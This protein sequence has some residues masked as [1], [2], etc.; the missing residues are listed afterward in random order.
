VDINPLILRSVR[1]FRRTLGE[2]IE[3]ETLLSDGLPAALVD[4][5]QLETAVL[6][7]ALN[8]RDAMPGNGLITIETA[9]AKLL[10]VQT[11]RYPDLS[12]GW[13]I[14]IALHDNGRGIPAEDLGKV[15]EP[16]FTTKE[17][18]KGTGLGLS[19]VYG[20]AKQ[21]NGH[22]VIES[23]RGKG[24]KVSLFL[25]AAGPPSEASV[26]PSKAGS[27]I[28]VVEDDPFVRAAIATQLD[29]LGYKTLTSASA[30]EALQLLARPE[31][32]NALFIGSICG[33]VSGRQLA[34]N[35]LKL[36]PD[37]R[38]LLSC[39]KTRRSSDMDK[40]VNDG[41]LLVGTPYRAL[42]IS[43]ALRM[44]VAA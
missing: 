18:G 21:S 14:M 6:N 34:D 37:L 17:V 22:I 16:F 30:T 9:T 13:Y 32:I 31:R 20:F 4:E 29:N 27:T 42:D 26:E 10:E 43:S 38:V 44:A 28:V 11:D 35:A 23:E 2:P 19:M 3:I 7:L 40:C 25:P 15:V 8:A 12:P 41:V 36:R 39:T 5:S 33:A 24:T 1:M